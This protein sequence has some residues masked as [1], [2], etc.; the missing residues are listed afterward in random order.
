MLL[1]NWN[2]EL[3]KKL[4]NGLAIRRN[5]VKFVE[6]SV[7]TV[8]AWDPSGSAKG[9]EA[10]SKFLPKEGNGQIVGLW[11]VKGNSGCLKWGGELWEKGI[12]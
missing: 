9:K 6:V 2:E 11:K 7:K 3:S 1:K 8:R 5:G 10:K 4:A 12:S